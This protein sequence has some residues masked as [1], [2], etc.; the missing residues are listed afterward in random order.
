MRYWMYDE[1]RRGDS[2]G[3]S[4]AMFVDAERTITWKHDTEPL[5]GGGMRVGSRYA[6]TMSW[7][8]YWTTTPVVEIISREVVT[9]DEQT[10]LVVKF[11][12]QSGSIYTWKEFGYAP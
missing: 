7:Q 11:K 9:E 3:M 8:D 10:T 12:T 4:D 1:R 6:R 5:I 2:G